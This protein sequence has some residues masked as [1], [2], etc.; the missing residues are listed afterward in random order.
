MLH[1]FPWEYREIGDNDT[2]AKL[3]NK[4]R[5]VTLTVTAFLNL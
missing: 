3:V 2:I 1:A 5:Y 4:V